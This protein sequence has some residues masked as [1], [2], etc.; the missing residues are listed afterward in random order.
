MQALKSTK[1][2][3]SFKNTTSQNAS[4]RYVLSPNRCTNVFLVGKEKFKDVCS[5]RM[6]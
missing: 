2:M 4:Q 3:N 5:K 1:T 6:L